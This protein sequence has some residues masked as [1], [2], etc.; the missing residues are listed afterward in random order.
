MFFVPVVGDI[1]EEVVVAG[2]MEVA[3]VPL[4]AAAVAPVM[5]VLP[6]VLT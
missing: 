3:Q 1:Q 4:T 2:I 5:S 6:L